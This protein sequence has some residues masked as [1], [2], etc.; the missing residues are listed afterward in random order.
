[1]LFM[2]V[3]SYEKIKDTFAQQSARQVLLLAEVVDVSPD[4][5]DIF[6]QNIDYFEHLNFITEP[7][8]T[9]QIIIERNPCCF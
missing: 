1:M 7:F 2:N 4:L 9:S 3:F 5:M 6:D 8:G